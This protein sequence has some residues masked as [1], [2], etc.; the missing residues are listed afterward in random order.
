MINQLS[1]GRKHWVE[2]NDIAREKFKTNSQTKVKTNMLKSCLY[3]Y[4]DASIVVKGTIIITGNK[5]KA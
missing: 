3:E 1:S 4:S 5:E 2:V